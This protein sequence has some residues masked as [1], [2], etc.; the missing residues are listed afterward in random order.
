M[1]NKG[2]MIALLILLSILIFA[3][4]I[5]LVAALNGKIGIGSLNFGTQRSEKIVLDETY[6]IEG[7]DRVKVISIAGNVEFKEREDNNIRVIAYGK[8]SGDVKVETHN[9]KI[10]IDYSRRSNKFAFFNITQN[11]IIVYIPNSYSNNINVN[12]DYGNINITDLEN[13][14]VEAKANCG[15]VEL[16]KVKNA[17]IKCDLGNVEINKL[18]NKCNIEVDCGDVK[19]QS[20]QLQEDS[21]IRCDLG[22][23]KIKEINDIYIDANVDLGNSKI[24]NN[25]RQSNVTLKVEVDCGDLKIEN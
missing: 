17:D 7:I 15:N 22:N 3:L 24:A 8:D 18:L 9:N 25:N 23:V 21:N 1:N 12:N 14:T 20:A 10:E 11:D 4:I 6:S 13:A 2:L 5:F 16:G 19:I